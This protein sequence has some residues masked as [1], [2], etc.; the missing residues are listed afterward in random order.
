MGGQ[1]KAPSKTTQTNEV[2]LSPEQ[3]ELFELAF[4]FAQQYAGN[5]AQLYQGQTIADFNAT[6]V[7]GQQA[8]VGAATGAGQQ[9]ANAGS[10]ASQ[11]L[12]NPSILSPDSNPWL[13]QQG[14]AVADTLS[15]Q[16][17]ESALPAIRS[18]TSVASGPYSGGSSREGIAQGLA[19]DRTSRSTGDALASLYG[20]AYQAGLSSMGD[21]LRTNPLTQASQL[22]G[23]QVLGQVGGQQ[24]GMEQAKLDEAS[25]LFTLEQQLP[26][27]QASDILSLMN[28]LPG[29]KGVST[30]AGAQPQTNPILSGLGGAATGASF[31][32]M[33]GPIGTGVGA[34]GGL[35]LSLLG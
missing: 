25:R 28:A 16:L 24:R 5:P 13:R 20:G 21:A 26:F 2:K 29:G 8:A 23:S 1:S 14:D 35:L 12:L 32:S 19:I 9:L 18:G 17:T 31:G 10:Q 11:F 4:P 27:L 6:E 22:F 15:R 34:A 30:V 33:F 3:Q 7:A